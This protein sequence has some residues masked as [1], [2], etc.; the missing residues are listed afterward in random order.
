MRN[1]EVA[2][3]LLEVSEYLSDGTHLRAG[4]RKREARQ[5]VLYGR[6]RNIYDKTRRCVCMCT[7]CLFLKLNEEHFLKCKP[8]PC[9][10]RFRLLPRRV[11]PHERGL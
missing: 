10:S 8:F 3:I 5:K 4:R 6:S 2:R 1:D 7:F 11:Y 9:R